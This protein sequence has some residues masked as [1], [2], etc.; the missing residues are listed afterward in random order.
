MITFSC[1]PRALGLLRGNWEQRDPTGYPEEKK[2]QNKSINFNQCLDSQK[3]KSNH[4]LTLVQT[5]VPGGNRDRKE[6]V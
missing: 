5:L 3:M 1:V 6:Q 4:Q 2:I